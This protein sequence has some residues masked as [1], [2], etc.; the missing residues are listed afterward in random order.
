MNQSINN[1]RAVVFDWA[2]TVVDF[3]SFAPMQAFV[4]LFAAEGVPLTIAQARGPMGL[5]KWQHIEAL[6]QLV[7]VQAKWQE[8][9][10]HVMNDADIDRL[11]DTFTPLNAA[12]IPFHS[13]LIPGASEVV[14]RARQAGLKIGSTTG[15]TRAIMNVLAPLAAEQGFTPDNCICAG[16]LPASRPSP[17][18]L[19]QT[20]VDLNVWP[21]H[22]VVKIDDTVPG[23]MEGKNA[24]CWTVGVRASG[25]ETGLSQDHWAALAEPERAK[26]REL[27]QNVLAQAQP[28]FMIDTVADL[29]PILEK[30]D[31]MVSMGQRPTLW[32]DTAV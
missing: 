27:A 25:N 19:Y 21:L 31:A 30:I 8:L 14:A 1:L 13:D 26:K 17:V 5:P 32:R 28:D 23:L 4:D 29:W 7:H 15:Y 18:G 2:G 22:H 24:G 12:A 9:H 16:D 6:G 3:G 20:L 11:H 10:G